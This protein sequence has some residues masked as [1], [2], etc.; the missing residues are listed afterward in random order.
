M[1]VWR[2]RRGMIE[3]IRKEGGWIREV[4]EGDKRSEKRGR[5]RDMVEDSIRKKWNKKDR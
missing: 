4:E 5:V 1:L 3:R 2:D